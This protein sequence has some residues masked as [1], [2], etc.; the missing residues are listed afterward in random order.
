MELYE[1]SFDPV[2][3]FTVHMPDRDLVFKQ[4]GKLFV[5]DFIEEGVVG[6]TVLSTQAFTKAEVERAKRAYEFVE[7]AGYPSKKP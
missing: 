3:G 7:N 2:V 6:A 5:A 1:I 4:R